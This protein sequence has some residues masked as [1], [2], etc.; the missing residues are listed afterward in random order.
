[1][2]AQVLPDI[3]W[4][5]MNN[6]LLAFLL[7]FASLLASVE[8]GRRTQRRKPGSIGGQGVSL[9]DG[10]VFALLGLLV[11]FSFSAA[12]SRFEARRDLIIA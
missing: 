3:G 8:I 9:L 5:I 2:T 6:A 12:A 7:I 10:A 4:H 1:M 11:G